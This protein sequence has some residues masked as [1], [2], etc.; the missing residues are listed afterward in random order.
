MASVAGDV[1]R[2][3]LEWLV[4]GSDQQVN[5]QHVVLDSVTPGD[6]DSDI[7]ADIAAGF[8][9]SVYDEVLTFITDKA[10]GQLMTGQNLTQATILPPTP[11]NIDGTNA[12]EILPLPV[13]AL[14]FYPTTI[15]RVQG[16][17]YLPTFTED[18]LTDSVNWL[19][20]TV[21]ALTAFGVGSIAPITAGGTSFHKVI[22][23]T[24]T[25]VGTYN[26]DVFGIPVA[27][28]TQRRRTPGRGG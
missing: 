7:M 3:A 20:A 14:V 16:R 25:G 17:T 6:T 28:R 19:A 13:T 27:P 21:T 18:A 12:G 11:N 22:R 24:Q 8:L 15:S 23:F 4:D 26:P 10:I 1:L 5:V 9:A 2:V